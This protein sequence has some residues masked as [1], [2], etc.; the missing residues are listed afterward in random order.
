[1]GPIPHASATADAAQWLEKLH[2]CAKSLF[3]F[4]YELDLKHVSR[5]GCVA[6]STPVSVTLLS[7]QEQVI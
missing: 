2:F 7:Y 3:D 6:E 5:I 4:G 1:M